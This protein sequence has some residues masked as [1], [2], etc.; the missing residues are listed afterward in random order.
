VVAYWHDTGL[1]QAHANALAAKLGQR[2][3][4]VQLYEHVDPG[5]PDAAFVGALVGA[6]EARTVLSSLPYQIGFMFPVDYPE[7]VGG[8][9]DGR[10]IGVGYRST[11]ESERPDP[12]LTPIPVSPDDLVTLLEPGISNTEFQVRLRSL[13]TPTTR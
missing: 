13:S 12:R 4:E 3:A 9:E 11:H 2:G 10:L 1:T 6:A 8:S 7:V 5:P